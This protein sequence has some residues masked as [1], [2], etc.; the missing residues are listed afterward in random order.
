VLEMELGM[1]CS[2]EGGGDGLEDDV[3]GDAVKGGE[4]GQ[5]KTVDGKRRG[6]TE[7]WIGEEDSVTELTAAKGKLFS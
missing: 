2:A 3:E 5:V 4:L 6:G 1:L 7:F